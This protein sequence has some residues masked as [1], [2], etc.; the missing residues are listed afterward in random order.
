MFDEMISIFEKEECF[1]NGISERPCHPES[2]MTILDY[3]KFYSTMDKIYKDH[4]WDKFLED[5]DY[6]AYLTPTYKLMEL[7]IKRYLERVAS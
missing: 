7:F 1:I 3:N 6:F 2:Y 5:L 4:N